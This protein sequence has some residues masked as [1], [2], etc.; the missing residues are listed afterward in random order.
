MYLMKIYTII[1]AQTT[2]EIQSPLRYNGSDETFPDH[3]K[4]K[5]LTP[6][7]IRQY[8][9]PSKILQHSQNPV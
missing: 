4:E 9:R 5:S 1:M 2:G 3:V 7:H 8:L 6:I